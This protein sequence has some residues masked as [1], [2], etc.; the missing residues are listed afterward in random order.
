MEGKKMCHRI[1][2]FTH[3]KCAL[4]HVLIWV[5]QKKCDYFAPKNL[6]HELHPVFFNMCGMQTLGKETTVIDDILNATDKN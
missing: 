4:V 1:I 3:L 2:L 6:I 5:I